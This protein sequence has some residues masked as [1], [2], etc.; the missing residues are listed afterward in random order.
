MYFFTFF[1]LPLRRTRPLTGPGTEP[2]TRTTFLSSST[3]TT[4]R[5][6]AV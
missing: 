3:L 5:S 2:L 6:E 4:T 1:V